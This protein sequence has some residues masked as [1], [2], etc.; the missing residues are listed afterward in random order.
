MA[1][2]ISE[3]SKA[4]KNASDSKGGKV[5][6]E[7]IMNNMLELT[8]KLKI[9]LLNKIAELER[10]MK[11]KA[12]QEELDKVRL[13]LE[14]RIN[15]ILEDL[16]KKFAPRGETNK[17][18]AFLEKKIEELVMLIYNNKDSSNDP[19]LAKKPLFWSCAS[20]DKECDKYSGKLGG[21][22][23]WKVFPPK[24]TSPER[25]GKVI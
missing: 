12:E 1:K 5:N 4:V 3:L 23:T 18:F 14:A 17:K 11:T 10:N 16:S 24:E 19:L 20:C 6:Q 25:M 2:K 15:Q 7:E 22:K 9:E 13:D 21:V 8:Q